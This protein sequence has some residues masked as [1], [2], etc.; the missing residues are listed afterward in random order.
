MAIPIYVTRTLS[1][2]EYSDGVDPSTL[3]VDESAIYISDEMTLDPATMTKAIVSFGDYLGKDTASAGV[4]LGDGEGEVVF[5]YDNQIA[6]HIP[7]TVRIYRY[8]EPEPEP[9]EP[10]SEDKEESEKDKTPNAPN[11][12]GTTKDET[13]KKEGGE[14][15]ETKEKT[16]NYGAL[17]KNTGAV[18]VGAAGL[19]I[20]VAFSVIIYRRIRSKR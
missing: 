16:G 19:V 11:T 8:V 20:S 17:F 4:T 15:S 3:T 13:E 7:T 18:S 14:N 10:E 5:D 2:E 12:D 1:S 6:E 9:A